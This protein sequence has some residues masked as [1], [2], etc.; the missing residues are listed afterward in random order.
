MHSRGGQVS[1]NRWAG[2]AWRVYAHGCCRCHDGSPLILKLTS[3]HT[4]LG[5][6][7]D[8]QRGLEIGKKAILANGD[9]K[10]LTGN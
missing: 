9:V 7:C 10:I 3:S 8:V 1:G 5:K 4:T 6:L 2:C